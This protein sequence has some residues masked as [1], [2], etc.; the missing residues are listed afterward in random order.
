MAVP[1]LDLLPPSPI[2][3]AGVGAPLF[4][5]S[6]LPVLESGS[7]GS[8]GGGSSSGG[9]SSGG[10]SSGGSSSGGSSSGG[11]LSNGPAFSEHDTTDAT[12]SLSPSEQPRSTAGPSVALITQHE[13][14][15]RKEAE[16]PKLTPVEERLAKQR[17]QAKK[18]VERERI[19]KILREE[20][21]AQ[22]EKEK[23]REE[24][25]KR[26]V[27]KGK[28]MVKARA[29][30]ARA[31]RAEARM[32]LKTPL[33]Q[34]SIGRAPP[35][36]LTVLSP[37]LHSVM[38]GAGGGGSGGGRSSGGSGSGSIR[39]P[40]GDVDSSASNASGWQRSVRE[41]RS[42]GQGARG[43]GRNNR[44]KLQSLRTSKSGRF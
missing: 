35:P 25:R 2:K 43:G 27:E 36:K 24:E 18:V 41:S 14:E 28:A 39:K 21:A 40:Y 26:R 12:R 29:V 19:L 44:Q 34:Q 11:A 30:K 32:T 1:V 20:M 38:G 16:G 4:L 22:A 6:P 33:S 23:E 31:A 15:E 13:Q 7:G 37:T 42:A 3:S 10:S 8:S 17:A 9:S 5:A